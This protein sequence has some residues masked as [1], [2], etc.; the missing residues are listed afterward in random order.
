MSA[1]RDGGARSGPARRD[2]R[3]RAITGQPPVHPGGRGQERSGIVPDE[4]GEVAGGA[5][6]LAFLI[7]IW[8]DDPLVQGQRSRGAIE[9]LR[10]VD[11]SGRSEAGLFAP[12]RVQHVPQSVAQQIEAQHDEENR[13]PRKNG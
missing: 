12:A 5:L 10:A 11:V 8:L 1:G 13:Q 9:D 6:N 2:R 3:A 7:E 4:A